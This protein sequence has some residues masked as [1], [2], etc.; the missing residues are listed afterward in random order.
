MSTQTLACHIAANMCGGLA[1]L[2]DFLI[3]KRLADTAG[4]VKIV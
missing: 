2:H 3:C 4:K 1:Y